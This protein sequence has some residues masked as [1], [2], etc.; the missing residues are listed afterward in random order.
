[1]A[2]VVFGVEL[3]PGPIRTVIEEA[4]LAEELGYEF[5]WFGDSHLIWREL[6]VCLTAAALSTSRIRI[7][8]GVTNLLTRDLTVTASAALT[9]QELAGPRAV[10]GLGAGDSPVRGLGRKPTPLS[11]LEAGIG[12]LRRLIAGESVE[13]DGKRVELTYKKDLDLPTPPI[14][15]A[16][17]GPRILRLAGRAADGAMISVGRAPEALE[18]ALGWV[19]EGRAERASG[20]LAFETICG[21]SCS[22]SED[23]TAAQR[24]VRGHVARLLR[25]PFPKRLDETAGQTVERVKGVYDYS[26]H[27]SS[28]SLQAEVVPLELTPR[29]TL[30]GTPKECRAQ[31]GEVVDLGVERIMITP[32]AP[33]K[34]ARGDV[35]ATF[36]REVMSAFV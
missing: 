15:V 6:W 14:I 7:G 23:R 33:E 9:L 35:I 24:A 8:T 18:A 27:M 2:K 17:S 11:E 13:L 31:L 25:Q 3:Y 26:R 1:M 4:R 20:E 28:A 34:V 5:V 19:A 30:A 32:F 12:K 29:F 21:F 36:G 22:V 16:G 10:L